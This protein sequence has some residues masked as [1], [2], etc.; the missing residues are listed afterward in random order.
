MPQRRIISVWFPSLKTDWFIRRRPELK[1]RGF[2]LT[3]RDHGRLRVAAASALAQALGVVPGLAL[4]EARAL[5]PELLAFEDK[6]ELAETLLSALGD[7]CQRYTPAAGVDLPEG[8]LLDATG[9][10]HLFGGE[11]AMLEDI[12]ARLAKL[13]YTAR[14]ALADTV[15]AA[16]ALARY[17]RG[18]L[19]APAGGAEAA[20]APLPPEALRLPQETVITLRRLGIHD[21]RRLRQLPMASL[22][23]RFGT[24]TPL[25]LAQA[26]GAHPEPFATRRPP[27]EYAVRLG[28]PEG[29]ATR[30]A[31]VHALNKLLPKLCA[32]LD[33]DEKG[34]RT[35]E[36]RCFR[37]DGRIVT[38]AIGTGRPSRAPR[39][40]L[41]LFEERLSDLDPGPG[42]E[43][44]V[45]S[46]LR[47][48][49]L[50]FTQAAMAG[51]GGTAADPEGLAE[52]LDRL[53]AR[54]GESRLCRFTPQ[55]SHWPE[56]AQRRLD[57]GAEAPVE[58][59]PQHLI[60]PVH[61][62]ARPERIEVLQQDD[63]AAPTLL[64]LPGGTRRVR[65]AEGPERIENEWW[66]NTETEILSP[67][68]R[69][70]YYRLED[71]AGRRY[72]VFCEGKTSQ[73]LTPRWFL[74]GYFG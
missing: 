68:R 39:H 51:T 71:E 17:G 29:I 46:A 21:I 14:A 40:L 38:V 63:A 74:H 6:P 9:G 16:W 12:T 27:P 24:E 15:G 34:L 47:A 66:R 28:F 2:A 67:G 5:I 56:R 54:L 11:T 19:L 52:L 42:I 4:A 59:W 26:L 25:R 31:L 10:A 55:Q 8:L 73:H 36:L 60:R 58:D 69:R 70:D 20:L 32:L 3:F 44:L 61:L 35:A 53:A 43:L 48:E 37:L 18:S 7:W 22:A 1:T 33:R 72:W 57:A 64:R 50:T 62:L 45:L 41:R 49:P 23:R 13:G 30:E 65:R